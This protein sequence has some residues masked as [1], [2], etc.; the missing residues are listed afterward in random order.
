MRSNYEPSQSDAKRA[1]RAQGI[2]SHIEQARSSLED[3]RRRYEQ[4]KKLRFD[5]IAVHGLYTVE[6]AIEHN[7]GAIM[8]PVFLASAQA[9]RNA[10]EMEAALSYQIPT[11]CY[12]RIHNPTLG[13][14]E[15][16]LALLEGYG[17]DGDAGCC[18]YS[19]GMAAIENVTDAL[20]VRQGNEPPNFVATC[21]VYGG[22]FQQFSVRK[23]AE[24]GIEVRWVIDANN[25]DE[26][27]AKIDRNTRFLYG[28]LPSNPGLAFF[29]LVKP[30]ALAH[31]F[32]IPFVVDSTIASPALLRPLSYGADI[33]IQSA[34]KVMS[35]TGA[36]MAGAVIASKPII[37]NIN[38]DEMKA[39]FALYLKRYPQRDQ[40]GC[41]HP[42]QAFLTL[43]DLRT[44]R[45]RVDVWS[46]SA[47][48]VARFLER[49]PAVLQV[50]YLG[51]ESNRL[52]EVASKYLWLVDAEYDERYGKPVNRYTPMMAFRVKGGPQATR[53]FF[54]RLKMVW[55]A[56]DLGRVKSVATIP[57]ISTHLLQGEESRRMAEIPPD[58][59]RL[60]I[61]AEHPDDIISD[62]DQALTAAR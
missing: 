38:N 2:R 36:G 6:E 8:E 16:T 47:L 11:W 15:D 35:A 57:A 56:T 40:G 39:D 5:T 54:D 37:S 52:H 32:G 14:L 59:V 3:R 33:V 12:T 53:R 58:M 4:A 42:L 50:N 49:H 30:I 55:R 43:A 13:Y 34:T 7:Q 24:R 25:I 20:L 51:L 46:Q 10:D 17:Y 29:D 45:T 48:K 23:M 19:S 18:V 61:G 9:Y 21:Q 60:S 27:R 41:L 44:L 1:A 28:E 22:T 26:W 62:L 31:E